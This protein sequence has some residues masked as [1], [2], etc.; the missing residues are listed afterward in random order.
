MGDRRRA[1]GELCAM[2]VTVAL[3]LVFENLLHLK[4][5]FLIPAALG[6]VGYIVGRLVQR[7]SLAAE[8]GLRWNAEGS[9]PILWTFAI[10]LLGVLC[11]RLVAGG[12]P[13]PAGAWLVFLAYPAWSLIQQFVL[14]VLVAS[15]LRLLGLDRRIIV[16]L[17]AVLF[18]LAHL[19]DWPLAALCT[20]GGL[21]WTAL[22]LRRPNLP[23]LALCHAWLGSLAFYWVLGRDPWL[24][25]R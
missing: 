21:A 6:W 20:I 2:G 15:N 13:L 9:L 25:M 17:C 19:P 8:W 16:P 18:G 1:I 23:L 5:V 22:Y 3:F 4:L 10:G 7:R 11:W 14:Q 24:E 12:G